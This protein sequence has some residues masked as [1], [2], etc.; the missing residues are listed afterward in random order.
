MAF[1]QLV[2]GGLGRFGE[3]NDDATPVLLV[4]VAPDQ[5]GAG[6]LADDQAGVGRAHVGAPG[7]VRDGG[8]AGHPQ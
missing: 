8:G 6:Q 3:G 5:P 4:V 7:Q 2:Y 1:S